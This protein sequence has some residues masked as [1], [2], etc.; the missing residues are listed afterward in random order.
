M[1]QISNYKDP[2]EL[3]V[4][5]RGDIEPKLTKGKNPFSSCFH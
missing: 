2:P 4:S 3:K 1:G 5:E